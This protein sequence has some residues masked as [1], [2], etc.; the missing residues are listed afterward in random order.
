MGWD[1][2]IEAAGMVGHYGDNMEYNMDDY[3]INVSS[4]L[5]GTGLT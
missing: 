1:W 4:S 3:V 2:D 5:G